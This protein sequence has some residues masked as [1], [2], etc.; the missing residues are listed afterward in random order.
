MFG[1]IFL[2]VVVLILFYLIGGG[3]LE[4]YK[5]HVIHETGLGIIMGMIVGFIFFEA[6]YEF[7]KNSM[8][9]E[10]ELFFYLILPPII[11]AGGYNLKKRRFFQN[12]FYI[13]IYGLLGT[14]VNF[15]VVW[16]L[17]YSVNEAGLIRRYSDFSQSV[18]L[19]TRDILLFSATICATDS[20]A[21]LAM[22]KSER[23]PKLFSVIFGEGMVNDSVSII[24]YK[25]VLDLVGDSS[26]PQPITFTFVNFLKM[27]AEFLKNSVCSLAIGLGWGLLATLVMKKFRFLTHNPVVETVVVLLFGFGSFAS[28]ENLDMSGVISILVC[29][30]IMSH[31]LFYNI[32]STGKVTTG[33]TFSSI[34]IIAE[35]ALYIYLGIVFW[36]TKGDPSDPSSY[37]WSWTF[38]L[39]EL[40]IAFFARF[41]SVF[42]VSW[43]FMLI[44]GKQKW[45]L[46]RYEMGII[47]FA[48]IIRGAIAFAL[49]QNVP[50]DES[51]PQA[52]QVIQSTT[53]FI[54]ILTTIILGGLMP[55]YINVMLK[56]IQLN[57]K[58]HENHPSIR[59]SLI[60]ES[61]ESREFKSKSQTKWKLFD[62]SF[63]KPFFIY[64]YE[65]RKEL[66]KMEK[67]KLKMN[68]SQFDAGYIKE[69]NQE[70]NHQE[71]ENVEDQQGVQQEQQ[72]QIENDNGQEE[73][74]KGIK[75]ANMNKQDVQSINQDPENHSSNENI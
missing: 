35:S 44:K 47:W 2:I 22:I 53:L 25:A 45:R 32:S 63:I 17:T 52:T 11:F 23:Y 5:I 55:I 56:Q 12:F 50:Q 51:N 27:I 42:V 49:I 38:L 61:K 16:L 28:S 72:I 24:L 4:H 8:I 36:Q 20:V 18:T 21:A 1:V 54:V 13:N 26:E 33:V 37:A 46:N 73:N 31:Y 29:G 70:M 43:I 30:I 10:G 7:Y 66:I 74:F 15:I 59:D 65:N 41:V 19:S 3:L 68:S 69:Q 75:R 60:G 34:S 71:N 6:D 40:A 64:D 58:Y 62:E 9:F 48:G 14:I 67:Q 57:P 39:L